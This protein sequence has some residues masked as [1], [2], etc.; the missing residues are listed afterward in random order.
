MIVVFGNEKTFIVLCQ[1]RSTS[2]KLYIYIYIYS[3]I[4]VKG[5]EHFLY[6]N[7]VGAFVTWRIHMRRVRLRIA[8]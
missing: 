1:N 3:Y 5:F 7:D 6:L 4:R 2:T 8:A